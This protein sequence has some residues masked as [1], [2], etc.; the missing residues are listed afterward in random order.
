MQFYW[1]FFGDKRVELLLVAFSHLFIY[2][3]WLI[4]SQWQTTWAIL[5]SSRWDHEN[6]CSAV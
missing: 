1:Q 4:Q 5:V 6:C 2:F 3:Y